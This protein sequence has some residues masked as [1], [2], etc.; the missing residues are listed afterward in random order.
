[1]RKEPF[2]QAIPIVTKVKAQHAS[3]I[4]DVERARVRAV[5]AD[6][7]DPR[8]SLTSNNAKVRP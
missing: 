3:A 4:F 1:M 2:I 5:E 8:G 7:G 6:E